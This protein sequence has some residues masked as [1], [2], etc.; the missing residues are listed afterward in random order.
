MEEIEEKNGRGIVKRFSIIMAAYNAEKEIE[1]AIKSV[2]NQTF[3]NFEFIVVNDASTDATAEIVSKYNN[4]KLINHIE[5]KRAG[6]ARNTGLEIANGEY[7]IFLDSDDV[8][9]DENVLAKIDEKIGNDMPD[10][11][12]LGFKSIGDLLQGEFIPNEHNSAKE[13]R[14]VEWKYENVWDV[15]WRRKYLNN[16]RIR[17]V[18]GKYFEDFVFYYKGVLKSS[19]YKFTDF[20]S[21]IYQSGRP[22]SMTT[23]VNYKKIKDLY[24]NM[25]ELLDLYNEVDDKYKKFIVQA[26]KRSNDYANRMIDVME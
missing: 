15:C 17:F 22:E 9:A 5:N 6:G 13:N 3:K 16:N 1:E 4:I 8:F 14:I 23:L 19:S 20:V 24:F 26:I 21:I 10:I 7:V 2:L 25:E 18:E 11:V 12:Y